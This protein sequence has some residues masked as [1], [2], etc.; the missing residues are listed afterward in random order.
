MGELP[1]DPF[2]PFDKL[3]SGLSQRLS[4]RDEDRAGKLRGDKLSSSPSRRLSLRVED[5]V[6]R[7][8]T[9][10]EVQSGQR[11]PPAFAKGYGAA[12][13]I[14]NSFHSAIRNPHFLFLDRRVLPGLYSTQFVIGR[15]LLRMEIGGFS[16]YFCLFFPRISDR[17]YQGGSGCFFSVKGFSSWSFCCRC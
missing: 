17:F 15:G 6:E 13:G 4:L 12:F 7:R 11:N 16:Y 3:T 14:R 9:N 10:N 8:V 1:F 5:R 2:D